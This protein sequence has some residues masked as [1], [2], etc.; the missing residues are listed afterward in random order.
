[1]VR[2]VTWNIQI[3]RPNPDGPSDIGRVIECLVPLR[4]DVVAIQEV[5]RGHRR[6]NRVD[7]PA[8]L[9]EAL[10]GRLA[11]APA[12]RVGGGDYGIAVVV[13][14]DILATET[15]GLS[16]TREPR[17][18]LVAE[19]AVSGR[20]W[21]I[22]CTHLSRNRRVARRQLVRVFDAVAPRP[23]PRVVLGDLNLTPREVLP[24]STAEGYQLVEG[25]A[26]H[27]TRQA[28]M[29]RRIDHVLLSGAT[30]SAASVH[31]FDVSDHGAVVADLT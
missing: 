9:A 16:G 15:V 17:V 2:V 31:R 3:G 6:S 27:S 18:L 26:T 29:T 24:W 7:Q 8:A 23:R 20:R 21:T 10:G 12:V 4:A 13:R 30:A 28:A 14:G 22:G 5:D 11:F 1:M 25:P 19:V